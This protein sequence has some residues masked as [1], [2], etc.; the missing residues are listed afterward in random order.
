ML[1]CTGSSAPIRCRTGARGMLI[2]LSEPSIRRTRDFLTA[3]E[4]SRSLHRGLVAPPRTIAAFRAYV[5]RCRKPSHIGHL[6]CRSDGELIG[7]VNLNEIVRGSFR[8]GYLGYYAFAPHVG[9]GYM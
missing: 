5:A 4:R 2:R 8:S 9:H 6:V 1:R 7:V 3:V